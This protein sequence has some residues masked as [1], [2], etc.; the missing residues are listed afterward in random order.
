MGSEFYIDFSN[1]IIQD[2]KA[3]SYNITKALFV[4]QAVQSVSIIVDRTPPATVA[5]PLGKLCPRLRLRASHSSNRGETYILAN[6]AWD[7]EFI[8]NGNKH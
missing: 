2:I 1:I 8:G 3:I 5:P 4:D 7:R 6:W